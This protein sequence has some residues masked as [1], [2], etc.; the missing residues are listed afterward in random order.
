MRWLAG[1]ADQA[2]GG[3]FD[4]DKQGHS[5]Y[6]MSGVAQKA[7]QMIEDAK[8][9][10]QERKREKL[11]EQLQGTG[12][13][14]QLNQETPGMGVGTGGATD[15]PIVVPGDHDLDADKYIQPK[16]GLVAEFLTD[17]VEFM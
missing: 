10:Q 11:K 7:G 8:Q 16:Y 1:A 3:F 6:Q 15:N 5:M 9:K 12:S 4:F 17:P 13:V 14:I 2:T